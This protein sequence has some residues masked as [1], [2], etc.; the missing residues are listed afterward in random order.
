M[1]IQPYVEKLNSS[2]EYKQF[3]GK[4]K[5]AFMMAGFF[6]LDFESGQNLHQ[7]D[8]YIPSEKKVAAFT[9]D[10]GVQVQM[11]QTMTQKTPEKLDIKTKTDLDEL[12]GILEDEMKNRGMTEEI[13][14]VIAVVQNVKGKCVWNLN[15][16][17]S[18]MEL[19]R[20]HIE[21][22]SKSVLK[23]DKV[24]MMDLMKKIPPEQ[25]QKMKAQAMGQKQEIKQSND[26]VKAKIAKLDKLK[27]AIEKEEERLKKES[28]D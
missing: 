24:S 16:V 13:K 7:I 14:K 28:K 2:N 5:D 12:K 11:L 25:L 4:Y 6:I 27:E 20:A 8:Y 17:L 22:S 15:C 9:L 10:K 19:L 3:S 1:K 21:D 23:M 18:G 26:N